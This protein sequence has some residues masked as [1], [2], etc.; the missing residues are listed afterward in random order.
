MKRYLLVL[1]GF[2]ISSCSVSDFGPKCT[3]AENCASDPKCQC[4]CS[5]KCGF[6][7]KKPDDSPI[8]ITNDSNGK[9][10]YCKQWDFDNYQDNCVEGKKI[11]QPS[12]AQ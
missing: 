3:T 4:W 10:C 11:P 2:L 6:R 5:R 7:N 8:Y 1:F 12:N 9:F